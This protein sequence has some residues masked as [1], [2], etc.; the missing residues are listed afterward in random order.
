MQEIESTTTKIWMWR[1]VDSLALF[2]YLMK[3]LFMAGSEFFPLNPSTF[4][5]S[6]HGTSTYQQWNPSP[7]L[8]TRKS[9]ETP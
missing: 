3:R 2:I 8:I 7:R 9:Y 4:I 1:Q 5:T 6:F